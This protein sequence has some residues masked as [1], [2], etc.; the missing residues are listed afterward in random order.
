MNFP[1]WQREK[2]V[3]DPRNPIVGYW[4]EGQPHAAIGDPQVLVPGEF[5]DKWHLFYH[6]FYDDSYTPYF[7]HIISDDGYNWEMLDKL[8]W[9]VN[10]I[11][12]FHDGGVWYVYYSATLAQGVNECKKYG[13]VNIIRVKRS[14]D[15]RNWSEASDILV[16]ELDWEKEFDPSQR[17]LI[18]A[19]NPCM[20]R[21]GDR[22]R[23]YYSAGTVKL[24]D[25]GYEEPKYIGFA[26]SD[27]PMGP[28]VRNPVPIIAPDK[29]I[30]YRNYGAG[31]IKVYG[32]GE[33]FLGLYNSI[34]V[35]AAG[36]SRSA[37]NLIKSPDGINWEEAPFNPIIIPAD[38]YES[39]ELKKKA[40]WKSTLVYQLDI[41]RWHDELR[42]YYNARE[43]TADGIEKIGCSVIKDSSTNIRKLWDI[44]PVFP[45]CR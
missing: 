31:A 1:R 23:L 21:I 4:G 42:I 30:R 33:E 19:R 11:N 17:G 37:I 29:S 40:L 45:D 16:P 5:D 20:V 24:H 7:H 38:E 27:S 34:Y 28:F 12:I 18:E 6:G 8:Q 35:D 2:W 22:Y 32:C 36:C 25:C 44:P 9:G 14:T 43:G 41:V 13:C 15:L 10:P 3:D 26:E 39:D